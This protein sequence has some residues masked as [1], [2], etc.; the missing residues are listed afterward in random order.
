MSRQ[1]SSR[2]FRFCSWDTQGTHSQHSHETLEAWVNNANERAAC[3]WGSYMTGSVLLAAAGGMYMRAPVPPCCQ[4]SRSL[5]EIAYVYPWET[6]KYWFIWAY[7]DTFVPITIGQRTSLVTAI[8][9]YCFHIAL[10]W[11]Y[12]V[13][14]L[15]NKST[16]Y[17]YWLKQIILPTKLG[18]CF[19]K[20]HSKKFIFS[21]STG[22][23][24]YN[25]RSFPV[26]SRS[27]C[28]F[29]IFEWLQTIMKDF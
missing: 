8:M 19:K 28:E 7:E 13:C 5:Y 12:L 18:C 17:N 4:W 20:W 11:N 2:L 14:I 9:I 15:Q 21:V 3:L 16:K 29:K 10:P 23:M 27:I 26:F 6:L 24:I 22:W 25:L 1:R